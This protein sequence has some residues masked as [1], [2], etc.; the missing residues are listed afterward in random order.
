MHWSGSE[1]FS[2]F[3]FSFECGKFFRA[4]KALQRV[5][6]KNRMWMGP[7]VF[8]AFRLKRK[9]LSKWIETSSSG[10]CLCLFAL[11]RSLHPL[12]KDIQ[13]QEEERRT[14]EERRIS[15]THFRLLHDRPFF[16]VG[17]LA[18]TNNN[19][20]EQWGGRNEEKHIPD[21][22]SLWSITIMACFY[23]LFRY[24]CLFIEAPHEASSSSQWRFPS[25]IFTLFFHKR[26]RQPPDFVSGQDC[27]HHWRNILIAR[28]SAAFQSHSPCAAI[29][30]SFTMV[31]TDL[32]KVNWSSIFFA[33][34]SKELCTVRSNCCS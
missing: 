15:K 28:L 24:Y 34:K 21:R 12:Q 9:S 27:S 16:I 11:L 17:L 6:A 20:R 7:R 4:W 26:A 22:G 29:N 14:A 25:S 23:S 32:D 13:H 33:Q 19:P 5:K 2:H 8:S 18:W 10:S 3:Y 30:N 31:F 1:P